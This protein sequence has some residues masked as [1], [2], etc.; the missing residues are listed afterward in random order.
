MSKPGEHYSKQVEDIYC[1][2][3]ENGYNIGEWS[4]YTVNEDADDRLDD[5]TERNEKE[6]NH[7]PRRYDDKHDDNNHFDDNLQ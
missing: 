1:K 6:L 4:G 5:K 2:F 3:Y 7:T